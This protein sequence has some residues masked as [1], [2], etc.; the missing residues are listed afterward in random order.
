MALKPSDK[1]DLS[2]R[3]TERLRRRI[4]AAADKNR[5][6]MNAEIIERLE[7]SFSQEDVAATIQTAAETT[8]NAVADRF[9]LMD[10]KRYEYVSDDPNE[11]RIR[12]VKEGGADTIAILEKLSVEQAEQSHAIRTLME[13]MYELFIGLG[14]MTRPQQPHPATPGSVIDMGEAVRKLRERDAK[15]ET[16]ADAKRKAK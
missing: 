7:R 1:A 3:F 13:G 5:R 4:E 11:E 9:I 8:A 14:L 15:S 12:E 16:N 10:G 2:L 6:S